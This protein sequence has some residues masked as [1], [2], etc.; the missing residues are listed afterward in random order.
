[1]LTQKDVVVALAGF[2]AALCMVAM[3]ET[4]P[5]IMHSAAFAWTAAPDKPTDVG[6]RRSYFKAPTATLSELEY[7]ATTLK[8]GLASHPPHRHPNEELVIVKEGTVEA[9]VNGKWERLG[10]GAVIFNASNELH[11]LRNVGDTP[12]TYH[13]INW[14]SPPPAATK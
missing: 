4:R 13:V 8:P 9:L 12:A 11:A 1:M 6:S 5:G 2:S 3:A 14:Q 10:A 7:H